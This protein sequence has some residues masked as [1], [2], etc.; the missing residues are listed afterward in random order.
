MINTPDPD[1]LRNAPIIG[2]TGKAGSGKTL[3]RDWILAEHRKAVQMSFARPIKRMMFELIEEVV[4]KSHPISPAEYMNDP[5]LKEQ[6][7]NF[8]GGFTPRY[9][10]QTLGTEWGR[11]A[12]HPDFWVMIAAAKVERLLASGFVN[13]ADQPLRMVFDDVRFAN[14]AAMVRA[15]RG[16]VVRIVRPN[17]EKPAEIAAHQSEAMDF[18][19]DLTLVNGGTPEDLYDLLRAAFPPPPPSP[20]VRPRSFSSQRALQRTR[21]SAA[22]E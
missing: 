8:L 15:Y 10:M 20:V 19:A 14:E 7:L 6:P 13:F 18:P 4:P 22:S 3:A 21:N 12:V 5:V 16:V 1:M 17:A 9:L 11:Q 2:F